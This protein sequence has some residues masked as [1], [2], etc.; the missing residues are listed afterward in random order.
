[1]TLRDVRLESPLF[2]ARAIPGR[3]GG[4]GE[5]GVLAVW[6]KRPETP[7]PSAS[8]RCHEVW[9]WWQFGRSSRVGGY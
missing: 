3:E 1:M 8:D 7:M 6:Q 9:Q 2:A 4:K 5:G